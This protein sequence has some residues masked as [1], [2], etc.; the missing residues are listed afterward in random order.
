MT[1]TLAPFHKPSLVPRVANYIAHPHF[2]EGSRCIP[3]FYFSILISYLYS[4]TIPSYLLFLLLFLA[5]ISFTVPISTSVPTRSTLV[6]LPFGKESG[7]WGRARPLAVTW[8][9]AHARN[10]GRTFVTSAQSKGVSNL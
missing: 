2:R 5:G 9:A 8:S 10:W 1:C 4:L 6:E 3:C 7:S